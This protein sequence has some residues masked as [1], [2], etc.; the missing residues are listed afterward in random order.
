MGRPRKPTKV[1]KAQGTF[2]ADRHAKRADANDAAGPLGDPPEAL[3]PDAK[4]EWKRITTAMAQIGFGAQVDVAALAAYC[5]TWAEWK[6]LSKIVS[7]KS[8]SYLEEGDRKISRLLG[9]VEDRLA[10]L[11]Q[12]FG[13][14]PA[15][16]AR[17]TIDDGEEKPDAPESKFF[18]AKG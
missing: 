15:S 13:F 9:T 7:A 12:Q 1:L 14:T 4:S 2:R 16:R 3:C 11:A 17:V 5:R 6:K 8:F 18:K 10:K